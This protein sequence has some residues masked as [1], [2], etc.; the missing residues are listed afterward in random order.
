MGQKKAR[1]TRTLMVGG[2]HLE[3]KRDKPV[4]SPIPTARKERGFKKIIKFETQGRGLVAGKTSASALHRAH[5][6]R[7]KPEKVNGST[8]PLKDIQRKKKKSRETPVA[9]GGS[10]HKLKR[11]WPRF[12]HNGRRGNMLADRG[13]QGTRV[14][15]AGT[16]SGPK[17]RGVMKAAR[18]EANSRHPPGLPPGPHQVS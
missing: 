4:P 2:A 17:T 1:D 7:K 10:A 15:S 8:V 13:A 9:R 18:V 5:A 6:P 12:V 16:P 11:N 14:S 3:E